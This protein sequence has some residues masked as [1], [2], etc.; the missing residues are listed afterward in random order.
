MPDADS[1]PDVY[2]DQLLF[3]TTL[4]GVALTFSKMPPN[5]RPGQAPQGE[6]QAVVRMSL[7]HAKVMVM[8]MKRQ[9]KNFEMENGEINIPANALNQMG[10]SLEDW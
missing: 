4:F 1:V 9:L 6:T 10:L 7:Q 3:T 8:V 5:P 2:A